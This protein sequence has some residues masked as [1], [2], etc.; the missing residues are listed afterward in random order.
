MMSQNKQELS[1][2]NLDDESKLNILWSF[3][4]SKIE[5][6]VKCDNENAREVKVKFCDGTILTFS[7]EEINEK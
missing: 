2:Y 1:A 6:I 4:E 3:I 7:P 5:S